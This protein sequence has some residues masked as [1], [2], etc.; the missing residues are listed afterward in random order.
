VH[1]LLDGAPIFNAN[2]LGSP[3]PASYSAP[4]NLLAGDTIDFAVGFGSNGN[5]NEDGTSLS[6]TIVPEP[7]TLGLVGMG[8]GCLLSLRFL[9][10]K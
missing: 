9:K 5:A 1:I 3:D 8:F 6:A 2:I 10:R 7:G 4:Q